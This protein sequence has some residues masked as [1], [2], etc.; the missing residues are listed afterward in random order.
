MRLVAVAHSALAAVKPSAAMTNSDAGRQ[1]PRQACRTSAPSPRRRSGRR[2]CTQA[3]SSALAD[4]PPWIWVSELVTICTSMIAMNRPVTI[5]R[6]P[7]P[8]APGRLAARLRPAAARAVRP[9]R[10]GAGRASGRRRGPAPGAPAAARGAASLPPSSSAGARGLLSLRAADRGGA[11]VGSA[12]VST[13]TVTDRPGRSIRASGASAG[14]A[15]RTGTRCTILVK[16][17]VALSGGSRLNWAP[18]AGAK[19]S[20]GR[21]TAGPG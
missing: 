11:P 19:L 14:K 1:Q 12:R 18:L 10:A 21:S 7:S 15:M 6:T 9:R 20:I 13:V 16:L 17:P 2:V 8:V 5:A 3:I 4:S